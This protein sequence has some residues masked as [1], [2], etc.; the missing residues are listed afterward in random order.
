M[1]SDGGPMYPGEQGMLPDG[2]WN[3]TWDPGMSVRDGFAK[4][5]ASAPPGDYP[6]DPEAIYDIAQGL[7]DEKLKRDQA[8][9]DEGTAK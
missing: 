2:T 6:T 4:A 7:T 5:I 8:D 9:R 1:P 3:Q